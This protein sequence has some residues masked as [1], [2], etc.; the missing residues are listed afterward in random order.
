MTIVKKN[1][2]EYTRYALS[3]TALSLGDGEL[4]LD[5]AER[6]RD[7]RVDVDVFRGADGALTIGAGRRYVAQIGI[8]A[9]R[10]EIRG[11]GLAD[12]MGFEVLAK[13]AV[14]LDADAVTLTLWATEG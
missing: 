8:P 14:P 7:Y 10:Y 13:T 5:L 9:R 3:G 2:G 6:E 1:A 12:D 4:T 11:T